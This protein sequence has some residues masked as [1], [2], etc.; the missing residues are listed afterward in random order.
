ML[1]PVFTKDF[2]HS[3]VLVFHFCKPLFG[4][5]N[6]RVGC[7]DVYEGLQH[8]F[9]SNLTHDEKLRRIGRLLVYLAKDGL[10]MKS[11]NGKQWIITEKGEKEQEA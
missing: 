8:V 10:I 7:Q 3:A 6:G 9:P 4:F 11:S 2:L 1:V 5:R